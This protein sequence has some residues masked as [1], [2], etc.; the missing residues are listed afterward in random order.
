MAQEAHRLDQQAA[1]FSNVL[2]T[3]RRIGPHLNAHSIR[4]L[5]HVS[6]TRM[7]DCSVPVHVMGTQKQATAIGFVYKKEA[8]LNPFNAIQQLVLTKNSQQAI[9]M[10]IRL[11]IRLTKNF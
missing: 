4:K 3:K 8:R 6:S 7:D 5:P 11:D 10:L 1:C 2:P 9:E